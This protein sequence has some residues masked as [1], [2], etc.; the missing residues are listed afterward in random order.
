LHHLP[1]PDYLPAGYLQRCAKY[2]LEQAQA[3]LQAADA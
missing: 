3:L 2:A 1:D